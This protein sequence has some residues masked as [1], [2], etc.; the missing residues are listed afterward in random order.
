MVLFTDSGSLRV[1]PCVFNWCLGHM[2]LRFEKPK[3]VMASEGQCAMKTTWVRE[4]WKLLFPLVPCCP[5][6]CQLVL[7]H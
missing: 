4:G 2:L 3:R 5:N 7:K 6:S 1:I